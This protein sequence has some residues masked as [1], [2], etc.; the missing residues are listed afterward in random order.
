MGHVGM[1]GSMV[2]QGRGLNKLIS[3]IMLIVLLT[4]S[5][6]IHFDYPTFYISQSITIQYMTE[7]MKNIY[8]R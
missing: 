5:E 1:E 7:I 4:L 6:I 3:M 8:S 2:S